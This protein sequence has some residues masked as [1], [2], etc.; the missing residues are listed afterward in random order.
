MS[1]LGH[2]CLRIRWAFAFAWAFAFGWAFALG[3]GRCTFPRRVARP[4]F[5]GCATA[6]LPPPP[7]CLA[8][9]CPI[10]NA[11]VTTNRTT[12][13]TVD[14]FIV[15]LLSIHV[16]TCW[17]ITELAFEEERSS[18]CNLLMIETTT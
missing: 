17:F 18:L 9:A 16:R 7:R 10:Q 8:S 13:I 2:S 11:K 3:S 5:G 6:G 14:T 12:T 1:R 15:R 4:P